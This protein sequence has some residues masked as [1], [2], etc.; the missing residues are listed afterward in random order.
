MLALLLMCSFS[1]QAIA[2]QAPSAPDSNTRRIEQLEEE[3]KALK[4]AL[5][6]RPDS[7][8][9]SKP[10]P[11]EVK[12][13]IEEWNKAKEAQEKEKAKKEEEKKKEEGS[14]VGSSLKLNA[15]WDAGGMRF[16]TEDEA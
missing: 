7:A 11:A 6:A 10:D 2:Q 16:K 14:V 4:A 12:K 1:R 13:L 3:I 8:T 15:S 9:Q 5:Q